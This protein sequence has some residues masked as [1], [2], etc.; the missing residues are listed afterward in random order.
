MLR[1]FVAALVPG[2]AGCGTSAPTG[3][4][5]EP[6]FVEVA[7][8]IAPNGATRNLRVVRS[9]PPGVYDEIAL[10]TVGRWR[11]NPHLRD[12]RAVWV[13][14]QKITLEFDENGRAYGTDGRLR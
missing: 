4:L 8:D 5:A 13:Y 7:Y 12:R 11:Y 10:R 1:C 9:E 2:F 6:G 3:V 14:D